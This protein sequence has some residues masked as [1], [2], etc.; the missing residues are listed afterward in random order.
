M[1]CRCCNIDANI[2]NAF[3]ARVSVAKTD[4]LVVYWLVMSKARLVIADVSICAVVE[5]KVAIVLEFL[6][7]T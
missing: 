1:T 2:S 7:G 4:D 5:T 3:N 6:C